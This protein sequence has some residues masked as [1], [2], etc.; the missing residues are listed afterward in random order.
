MVDSRRRRLAGG[1]PARTDRRSRRAARTLAPRRGAWRSSATPGANTPGDRRCVAST[2]GAGVKRLLAISWEMPPLSGPRAVQVTRTL[3]ALGAARLAVA[4][5][6]FRRAVPTLSAGLPRVTRGAVGWRRDATAGAPRRKSGCS[7]ARCGVC[8]R[9]L[10]HL[11]D[12][13][14]VWVPS[15][16]AEGRR[17]LG[18]EPADVIVSFA[19]PW[20]DHLVGLAPASRDWA[21]VG[22]TLFRSVGGQSVSSAGTAWSRHRDR[23]DGADVSWSAT[24]SGVRQRHTLDRVMEKYPAEWRHRRM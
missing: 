11:P 3:L 7:S 12:E 13:K 20:S 23:R 15:A 17:A 2:S 8:C 22:R 18:D 1:R 14:R 5:D 24:R 21:A 16:I 6:L 19:Q 4:R 10:K 9:S